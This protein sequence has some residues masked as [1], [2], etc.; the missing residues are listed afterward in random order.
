MKT[1]KNHDQ[2]YYC[3]VHGYT[4]SKNQTEMWIQAAWLESLYF[5]Q[6]LPPCFGGQLALITLQV[7]S[8]H[9]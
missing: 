2:V 8:Q 9:S 1:L 4:A 5:L 7:T 6:T 3:L